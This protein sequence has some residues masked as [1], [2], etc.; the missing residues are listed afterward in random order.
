[1][2]RIWMNENHLIVMSSAE[3]CGSVI[4]LYQVTDDYISFYIGQFWS[5]NLRSKDSPAIFKNQYFESSPI[6]INFVIVNIDHLYNL[7]VS[8][9]VDKKPDKRDNEENRSLNSCQQTCK[10]QVLGIESGLEI[11]RAFLSKT[12]PKTLSE[13]RSY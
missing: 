6:L 12:W 4:S 13:Q 9:I 3:F 2:C 8:Q 11:G 7:F 5:G 1:M 10:Y